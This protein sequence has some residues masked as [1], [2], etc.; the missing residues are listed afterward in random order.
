M[1]PIT[2]LFIDQNEERLG[3]FYRATKD[4]D[5]GV[6]CLLEKSGEDAL[7]LLQEESAPAPDLIFVEHDTPG[8]CG[9]DCVKSIKQLARHRHT[10]VILCTSQQRGSGNPR[11]PGVSGFLSRSLSL[12]ELRNKLSVAFACFGLRAP[13]R[14]KL[15]TFMEEAPLE[16]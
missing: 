4:I 10:P 1:F 5:R 11:H 14:N 12:A 9:K 8:I 2:L 6:H 16:L 13:R 7:L 3:Y 15:E